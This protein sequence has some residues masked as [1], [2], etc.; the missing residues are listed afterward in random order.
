VLQYVGRQRPDRNGN[1]AKGVTTVAS[2]LGLPV[3][4]AGESVG[5]LVDA[6]AL[7]RSNDNGVTLYRVEIKC[8][9]PGWLL[10]ENPRQVAPPASSQGHSH[11]LGMS[12]D[13][14]EGS[15][16]TGDPV[17]R[18]RK[19]SLEKPL[20]EWGPQQF[21]FYFVKQFNQE[22]SQWG[23]QINIPALLSRFKAWK[24]EGMPPAMGKAVIDAFC[25]DLDRWVKPGQP[26]W[27]S[28]IAN[29]TRLQREAERSAK[30]EMEREADEMYWVNSTV[31]LSIRRRRLQVK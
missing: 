10:Q 22:A 28:F 6:G 7:D 12:Y 21:T 26:A 25:S 14:P 9:C 18:T 17:K 20:E 8:A 13:D 4:I 16:R 2:K 5:L 24:Q 3:S 29:C 15:L 23:G 19:I 27:K 1:Y 31:P 11:G 30:A